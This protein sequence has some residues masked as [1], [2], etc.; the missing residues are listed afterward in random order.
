M[1][2]SFNKLLKYKTN[3][4]EI[5][6]IKRILC[7]IIFNEVNKIGQDFFTRN[8]MTDEEYDNEEYHKCSNAYEIILPTFI[9]RLYSYMTEYS[10]SSVGYF[11]YLTIDNK[12][13]YLLAYR[14]TEFGIQIQNEELL[15][16]YEK[17]E[18]NSEESLLLNNIIKEYTE[19]SGL[20]LMLS[21][22]Y[23][24][25]DKDDNS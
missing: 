7:L 5:D 25:D 18:L 10:D 23:I 22:L 8:Y 9:L 13:L 6:K 3:I 24:G 21:N 12:P 19:Y 16:D 17:E 1:N 15:K 11:Y 20:S 4:I 2:N 14:N